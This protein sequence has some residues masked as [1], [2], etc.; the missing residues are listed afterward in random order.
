MTPRVH[1]LPP[2]SAN[3]SKYT[4]WL[5]IAVLLLMCVVIGFPVAVFAFLWR[6]RQHIERG[7]KFAAALGPLFE[8][9]SSRVI[10]IRCRPTA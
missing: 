6:N 2:R 5:V 10:A 1:F 3:N 7:E 4:A 9:S 8:V